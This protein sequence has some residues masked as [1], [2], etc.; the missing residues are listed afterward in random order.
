MLVGRPARAPAQAEDLGMK[1]S[2]RLAAM[3]FW[4]TA[5]CVPSACLSQTIYAFGVGIDSCDAY[6][7]HIAGIPGKSISRTAP[8][9]KQDYYSKSTTY[10]EWL[11]G[12]ITGYNATVSDPTNQIQLDPGAVDLHVRNWCAQ[13]PSSNIFTAVLQLLEKSNPK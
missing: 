7:S 6:I 4:S 1:K 2:D 11:L 10:L 13:N 8:D 3:L 5:L 12:F 9:D